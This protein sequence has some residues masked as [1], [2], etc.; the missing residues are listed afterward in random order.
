MEDANLAKL[1]PFLNAVVLQEAGVNLFTNILR[2]MNQCG[3]RFISYGY[4][5][6]NEII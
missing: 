6:E 4:C 1:L 3:I 5:I 2:E